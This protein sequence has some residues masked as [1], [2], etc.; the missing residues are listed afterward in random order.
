MSPFNEATI[1][2]REV[3]EH[4]PTLDL[5]QIAAYAQLP[6]SK[7]LAALSELEER[8]LLCRDLQAT[9]GELYSLNIVEIAGRESYRPRRSRG[10]H[11][12]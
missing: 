7:T 5:F 2:T 1:K 10:S 12:S 9:R 11:Q 4:H 6:L 3:L 8:G